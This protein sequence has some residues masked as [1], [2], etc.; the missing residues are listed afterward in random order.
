MVI[1]L[2]IQVITT[3]PLVLVFSHRFFYFLAKQENKQ[4]LA[5]RSNT[6]VKYHALVDTTFEI[7]YFDLP[8]LIFIVTT[9]VSSKFPTMM[10][11]ISAIGILKLIVTSF[12][13]I[14]FMVISIL[15]PL[16]LLINH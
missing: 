15:S 5:A 6:K 2:R 9:M 8:P 4:T 16:A 3:Q 13:N 11:F 14:F 7:S 1:G 10:F 12:V